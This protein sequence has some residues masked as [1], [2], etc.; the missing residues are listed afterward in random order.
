MS[1]NPIG[2]VK[3]AA[4]LSGGPTFQDFFKQEKALTPLQ[5]PSGSPSPLP[6]SAA[7]TAGPSGPIS[8]TPSS[9]APKPVTPGLTKAGPDDYYHQRYND[10]VARNPCAT[11][12]D[13]YLGYGGKYYE[14][15]M[16]LG[17]KLSPEGQAW[18]N[19]TA[20]ALQ[21]AIEDKR[22]SDPEGFAKLERDPKAFRDFAFSTHPDAYV[23]SGLY[24][25]PVQ[26]ILT[27]ASTPDI[28]DVLSQE[29]IKQ[30]LIT[31]G[32]LSPCDLPEIA[33]DT[34]IQYLKDTGPLAF[35]PLGPSIEIGKQIWRMFG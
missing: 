8:C 2:S 31:A 19:K 35:T 24:D 15:F 22:T 9:D 5:I 32:K 17:N 30:S 7:P 25:L 27:I 3:N 4:S 23:N 29:G 6:K 1:V 18:C 12:P 10:F 11:P 26:D 16:S 20:L 21:Q 13:Y 33:V 14:R 28:K 34:E